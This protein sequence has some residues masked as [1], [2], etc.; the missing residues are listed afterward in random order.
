MSRLPAGALPRLLN[1]NADRPPTLAEHES[2]HGPLP[3][4]AAK[5][6][7]E[8]AA[9][10]ALRGRGGGGFPLAAKVGAVLEQR[11]NEPAVVVNGV[12]ADPFSLK[13]ATL[14]ATNPH[15]VLDGAQAAALA[16]GA[17]AVV[18]AVGSRHRQAL[19]GVTQAARERPYRRPAITVR[20]VPDRYILGQ[21]SALIGYLN[22]KKGL[23]AFGFAPYR[24]GLGGRPTLVSNVETFAQLG[25]L[26]H[27]GE[28]WFRAIGEPAEP[29]SALITVWEGS[30]EP[31]LTEVALGTPLATVL[32]GPLVTPTLVGG[33]GGGWLPSGW[34][35][36]W[37]RRDLAA[38]GSALGCGA[39]WILPE[40]ACPLGETARLLRFA[41]A[42]GAAQCG[43][44]RFGTAELALLFARLCGGDKAVLGELEEVAGLLVGRGACSHPDGTARLAASALAAFPD[45]VEAHLRHG[46]CPACRLQAGASPDG[47]QE[48]RRPRRQGPKP[49]TPATWSGERWR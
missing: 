17:P 21:E 23:P 2:R 48:R 7:V 20:T 8:L 49:A 39:A 46:P 13:D 26:L 6:L 4:A 32:G 18:V 45:G 3:T 41:A 10:A 44:C 28:R 19:V 37:S 35:G 43:P 25:L 12:E 15:L 9:A 38:A 30:G 33:L 1:A 29:G 5:E 22:G 34:T 27:H 40:G 42:A 16:L 31:T 11:R 14:L 24:K 36:R 47:L